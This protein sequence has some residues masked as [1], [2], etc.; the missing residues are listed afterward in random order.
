MVPPERGRSNKSRNFQSRL[1]R[2]GEGAIPKGFPYRE[3][4]GHA[5]KQVPGNHKGLGG[6]YQKKVKPTDIPDARIVRVPRSLN[7]AEVLVGVKSIRIL[8]GTRSNQNSP[9]CKDNLVW[10]DGLPVLNLENGISSRRSVGYRVRSIRTQEDPEPG[11]Y[12][13]E[14]VQLSL[15]P[16]QVR[17]RDIPGIIPAFAQQT[18]Q[19]ERLSLHVGEIYFT[20]DAGKGLRGILPKPV[21]QGDRENIPVSWPRGIDKL[22]G[23]FLHNQVF[24]DRVV[25]KA[26]AEGCTLLKSRRIPRSR[27][28][29]Y[30]LNRD[31]YKQGVPSACSPRHDIF[32][33][34]RVVHEDRGTWDR[35]PGDVFEGQNTTRKNFLYED[36]VLIEVSQ[37]ISRAVRL[38]PLDHLVG[39]KLRRREFYV[40]A[41]DRVQT[42]S[43]GRARIFRVENQLR[44]IRIPSRRIQ[45]E[46]PQS[47]GR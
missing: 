38:A 30:V 17:D 19:L 22:P 1:A 13:S 14:K 31:P 39:L 35:V 7:R 47:Q 20:F 4:A 40:T 29:I 11:G 27:N 34:L 25:R 46:T 45:R 12:F 8:R 24:L 44:D 5:R 15:V 26:L 43:R 9:V 32:E 33:G 21:L 6:F 2:K 23:A 41:L 18:G 28:V 3:D 36:P 16:S 37:G 42:P 10:V